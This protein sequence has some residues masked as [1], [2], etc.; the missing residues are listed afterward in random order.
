M[1][2]Q[3]DVEMLSIQEMEAYAIKNHISDEEANIF[4]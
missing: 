3:S 4:T 1:S 2:I